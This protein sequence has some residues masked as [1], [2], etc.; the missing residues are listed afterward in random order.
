MKSAKSPGERKMNGSLLQ[1]KNL[2]I[3]PALALAA[4]LSFGMAVA[5]ESD[6]PTTEEFPI[7]TDTEVQVGQTF[8]VKKY[9]AWNHLCTKVSEGPDACHIFQSITDD[10]GNPVAEISLFKLPEGGVAEAGATI[11]TPLRTLL[12]ANLV[13][14]IDGGQPKQ[15][16]FN[17]C[18]NIGCVARI[19]FT[20]VELASLKAGTNAILT[21]R[22]A[23]NPSVPVNLGLSLKGFTAAYEAANAK[24]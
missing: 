20:G 18:E 5:Q 6:A 22:S 3:L 11:I 19:G 21:L 4:S 14:T 12:T 2:I 8:L 24:P 7:G 9:D 13:M 10:K 16:P 1:M 17:W 15:Y 23:E